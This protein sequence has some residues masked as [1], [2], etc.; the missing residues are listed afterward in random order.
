MR[1][2]NSYITYFSQRSYVNCVNSFFMPV[3]THS[4]LTFIPQCWDKHIIMQ[5]KMSNKGLETMLLSKITTL[6]HKSIT[7]PYTLFT[8]H[9]FRI[10][11]LSKFNVLEHLS[12]I[13][14]SFDPAIP[15]PV[16][17]TSEI[18]RLENSGASLS[19]WSY[20]NALFIGLLKEN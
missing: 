2:N 12:L 17:K 11:F 19:R 3:P 1:D 4:I 6:I 14:F 20:S 15:M 8:A 7:A 16:S 10:N 18:A 13:Y 5:G 9:F